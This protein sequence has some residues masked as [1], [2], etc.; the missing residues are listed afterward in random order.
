MDIEV[1]RS[2]PREQLAIKASA[3]LAIDPKPIIFNHWEPDM[4]TLITGKT[5]GRVPKQ[6]EFRVSYVFRRSITTECNSR[7]QLTF[8]KTRLYGSA[9]MTIVRSGA[10]LFP[11]VG[12]LSRS[13]YNED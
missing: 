6:S 2:L 3:F 13:H 8:H 4:Q 1:L 7:Q 5:I 9:T 10:W 12:S 11:R